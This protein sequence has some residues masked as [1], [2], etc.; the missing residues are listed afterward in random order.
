MEK[1]KVTVTATHE[2]TWT[3]KDMQDFVY[4]GKS[5][6]DYKDSWENWRFN[7]VFSLEKI[8]DQE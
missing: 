1:I 7:P 8:E 4:D 5:F 6:E 2:E 3:E